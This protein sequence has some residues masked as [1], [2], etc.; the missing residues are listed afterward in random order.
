LYDK[1]K[2]I[3]SS[4]VDATIKNLAIGLK[5]MQSQ[6][7]SALLND[8]D[9][10]MKQDGGHDIVFPTDA[11]QGDVQNGNTDPTPRNECAAKDDA[12]ST[13]VADD[14][15]EH[16]VEEATDASKEPEVATRSVAPDVPQSAV[17]IEAT[18][19]SKETEVA[20]RSI[21][22][23]VPQSEVLIDSSCKV[24]DVEEQ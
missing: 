19:V 23:D 15:H 12:A 16:I 8:I 10:A 21:A 24:G 4:D 14:V 20:V 17:L 9:A 5:R 22:P 6:R 3:F 1:H 18:Y 7:M 2:A 11:V 13:V